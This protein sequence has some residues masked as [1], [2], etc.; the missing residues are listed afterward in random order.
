MFVPHG[1]E[2]GAVATVGTLVMGFEE[3]QV[4]KPKMG[5]ACGAVVLVGRDPV[6]LGMEDIN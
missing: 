2:V 5:R 6:Q 3:W 4:I 1:L